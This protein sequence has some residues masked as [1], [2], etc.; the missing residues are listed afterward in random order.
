MTQWSSTKH[1]FPLSLTGKE[2][3]KNIG[4]LRWSKTCRQQKEWNQEIKAMRPGNMSMD[5]RDEEQIADRVMGNL[6]GKK[7]DFFQSTTFRQCKITFCFFV[8]QSLYFPSTV[9]SKRSQHRNQSITF[10]LLHD[11][12]N[13]WIKMLH[14]LWPRLSTTTTWIPHILLQRNWHAQ[15]FYM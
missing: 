2:F 3:N 5:H 4:H 15:G 1:P 11:S 10:T 7:G 8:H 12:R 9:Y 13:K 6:M 14:S